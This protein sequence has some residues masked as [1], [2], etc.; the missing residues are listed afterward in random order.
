M[1]RV[2]AHRRKGTKGVRQHERYS[3]YG[4]SGIGNFKTIR[5]I[6]SLK[7]IKKGQLL[8]D[9][10]HQFNAL[11]LIRVTNTTD[12]KTRGIIYGIFVNPHNPSVKR[13]ETD[14]EFAIWDF[15]LKY[16]TYY[17]VRR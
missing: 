10:S 9:Y 8:A 11:N 3:G 16:D 17:T 13:L 2:R 6:T 4:G 5:R 15:D 14:D 12:A 1:V 7:N